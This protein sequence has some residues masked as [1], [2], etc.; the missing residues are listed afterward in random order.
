M[1]IV[2]LLGSPNVKGCSATVAERFCQTAERSGAE[3]NRVVLNQLTY[4]GCQACMACKGKAD[5]C[6]IKDDLA[7]VLEAVAGADLLVMASPIYFG[8][9]TAQLKGFIDRMY[10]WLTPDFH[11]ASNK[12]RLPP[13]RK[14]VFVQTQ[15]NA[16]ETR[17]ADVFPRYE[18]FFNWYGYTERHLLRACGVRTA[19]DVL[20]RPEVMKRAED[21][22]RQLTGA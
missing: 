21:L 13:G 9:V 8:E 5:H 12:S 19:K 7:A 2:C 15:G 17:F 22:A 14:L 11:T 1:K 4:R 6:V 16:D 3:V 10:C 20:A 18:Y